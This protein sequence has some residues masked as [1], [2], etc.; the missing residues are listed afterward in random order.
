LGAVEHAVL[1]QVADPARTVGQQLARV[2]LLD[3]LG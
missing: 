2:D 3:V 1:E